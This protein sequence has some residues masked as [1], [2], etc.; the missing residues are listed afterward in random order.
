MRTYELV[1]VYLSNVDQYKQGVEDIKGILKEFKVNLVSEE[2]M[3]DRELTYPIRKETRGHYH[4]FNIE[5]DPQVI[6]E[7]EQQMKL[8]TTLLK[9]L[10]VKKEE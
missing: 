1:C 8:K 5:A 6:V 2:D 10:F 9:Y 4:L 3:K 7:M